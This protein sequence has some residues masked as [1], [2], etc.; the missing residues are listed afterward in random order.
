MKYDPGDSF[1]FDSEPNVIPFGS[2]SKGKLSPKSYS[3]QF[4]RKLRT[5]LVTVLRL[6][7]PI[8]ENT[9][10]EEC[11]RNLINPNQI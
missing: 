6:Y 4:E 2:K 5:I 9:R 8:R 1:S 7:V 10:E 11:L 3:I